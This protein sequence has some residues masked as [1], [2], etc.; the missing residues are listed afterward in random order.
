MDVNYSTALLR[1]Y[2]LSNGIKKGSKACLECHTI[3]ADLDESD[4]D[5]DGVDKV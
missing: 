3:H 1:I 4:D 2:S 5:D